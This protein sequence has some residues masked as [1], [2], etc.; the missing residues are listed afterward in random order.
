MPLPGG[1]L[2]LR[3]GELLYFSFEEEI[4]WSAGAMA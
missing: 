3:G 2:N 1:F 4:L